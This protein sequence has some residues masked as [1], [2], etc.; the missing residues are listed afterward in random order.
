MISRDEILK[1]LEEEE[2]KQPTNFIDMT[3]EQNTRRIHENQ[4]DRIYYLILKDK[5]DD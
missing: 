1:V 3:C 2:V 4:A 5:E